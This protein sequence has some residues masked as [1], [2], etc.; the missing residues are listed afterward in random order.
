MMISLRCLDLPGCG[1]FGNCNLVGG[2]LFLILIFVVTM[3]S[4]FNA[5]AQRRKDAR[6]AAESGSLTNGDRWVTGAA[7]GRILLAPLGLFAFALEFPSLTAL[8]RLGLN[9]DLDSIPM[10]RGKEDSD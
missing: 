8:M 1:K 7:N 3:Q 10:N 6:A 5:K 2:F 4:G 9:R